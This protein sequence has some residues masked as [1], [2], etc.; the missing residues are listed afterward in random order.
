MGDPRGELIAIQCELA[1]L[2]ACTRTPWWDWTA[3]A[4]VDSAAL[5]D[6]RIARLRRRE[7]ELL[8]AHGASWEEGASHVTPFRRLERGFVEHIDWRPIDRPLDAETMAW[9]LEQVPLLRSLDLTFEDIE[10]VAVSPGPFVQGP[11]G[12]RLRRLRLLPRQV[13]DLR[14]A[15]LSALRSIEIIPGEKPGGP[16]GRAAADIVFRLDVLPNLER[17]ELY[18]LGLDARA[19]A[20]L[21]ERCGAVREIELAMNAIGATGAECL[22]RSEKLSSLRVLSLA[23]NGVGRKAA[24]LVRLSSLRAL[25]LRENR[26]G[27]VAAG[28]IGNAFP[29]LRTLDVSGNPLRTDGVT[30]LTSGSGLERLRVLRLQHC[31]LD[32]DA[33]TLL[34]RSPFLERL[35][36]LS[37]RSNQIGL[38]GAAALAASPFVKNLV[39]LN[40]NNNGLDEEAVAVLDASPNLARCRVLAPRQ[41]GSRP[42]TR[43]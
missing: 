13:K 19:V 24:A 26:L 38:E 10:G 7:A 42:R 20:E 16:D 30:A 31:G 8:K 28:A 15:R 14:T 25:D 37:L 21:L 41:R 4:C 6:G 9:V 17:I 32:D 3:D 23:G 18:G 36:R 29:E 35:H 2:G 34:A 5:E 40:L 1:R 33:A 12:P 43:P 39:E 11:L 22:A 27:I